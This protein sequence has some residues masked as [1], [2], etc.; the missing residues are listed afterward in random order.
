M[1]VLDSGSRDY[2]NRTNFYSDKTP[3]VAGLETTFKDNFTASAESFAFHFKSTSESEVMGELINSQLD[4]IY[5]EQ[6]PDIRFNPKVAAEGQAPTKRDTTLL[7]KIAIAPFA[8][9]VMANAMGKGASW[10]DFG[11]E[12]KKKYFK[13]L[14]P[15]I[16]D[17]QEQFPNSQI[18]TWDQIMNEARNESQRLKEVLSQVSNNRTWSGVAGMLTGVMKEA[19]TD[20]FVLA[21][22]PLGWKKITGGTKSLNALK[23]FYTEFLIGAGSETLIQPFVMD[24]SAKLETPWVLKDAVVTIMTVGGFAGVTRAAGSYVVDLVE[25]GK[26]AKKLRAQGEHVK[27]DTLENYIDL[28]NNAPTARTVLDQDIQLKAIDDMQKAID[29]GRVGEELNVEIERIAK[30]SG[31]DLDLPVLSKEVLEDI[32]KNASFNQGKKIGVADGKGSLEPNLLKLI[33]SQHGSEAVERYIKEVFEVAKTNVKNSTK[34]EKDKARLTKALEEQLE[35]ELVDVRERITK[36]DGKPEVIKPKKVIYHGTNTKFDEFDLEK[37]ADGTVWFTSN[38]EKLQ[39]GQ[40]DGVGS[41]KYIVERTIDEDQLKLADWDM[42][43]KHSTQELMDMGYDGLRLVDK[44][45]I[46]YRIFDPTKLGRVA[47]TTPEIG[48][49]VRLQDLD[50]SSIQKAEFEFRSQQRKSNFSVEEYHKKAKPLQKQFEKIGKEIAEDLGDA[51]LFLSPGIKKLKD[52]RRKVKD[53]YRG[54]TG[55]LTDV[56][57]MGFAVKDYADTVKIIKTISHKYE[58]LDEGFVMNGAGYFDHKLIVRFKNGQIG[59][60]QMWEPHL[61]AA[62]EGKEYVDDLF[63]KD[64]KEFISDFDVPLRK[65][66]GHDIYAKQ[67]ELLVD[68]VLPP[69]NKKKDAELAKKQFKLYSR[70]N[71]FS[72]TSW[73]TALDRVLPESITSRGETGTQLPGRSGS[74]IV[75]AN[76]DPSGGPTTTAGK[77]S[78]LNQSTTSSSLNINSTSKNII[79]GDTERILSNDPELPRIMDEEVIEA[80]RII[81]EAG[82]EF[83][84]PFTAID[85]LG[86]ET[87]VI[88]SV[89]KVFNDLD[90]EKKQLDALNKCMGRAA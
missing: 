49:P 63:T 13:D 26:A 16:L 36:V 35:R 55:R 8:I 17:L 61:L 52:V 38:R 87:T 53:K 80:Q 86:N 65:D 41:S 75:N 9:P 66:S 56:I 7:E 1:G 34:S 27:A 10:D 88:Q 58:I 57:R 39:S 15:M 90:E 30:E 77:P 67:R 42:Y 76:K 21:S 89:K 12:G 83:E 79:T 64:M 28:F 48:K 46:T 40:Y 84:I 70:A 62:K 32:K 20:P 19:L 78:Q 59:E 74:S 14:T 54:K 81:D 6:N 18:K 82:D 44:D 11:Y 33:N 31:L 72:K 85:D 45:E 43:D 51:V 29:S 22:L 69:K 68:G 73:K 25:A 24:W 37:T 5:Q 60:I 50:E 3:G 71:H 2:L 23:A 4:L 47:S